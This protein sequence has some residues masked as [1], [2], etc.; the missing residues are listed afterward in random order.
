MT[1]TKSTP[2]QVRLATAKDIDGMVDVFFRSF[3]VPFFRTLFPPTPAT[4]EWL[5][6]TF[7][8][9]MQ[10]DRDPRF[11]VV[12]DVENGRMAAFAKWVPPGTRHTHWLSFKDFP[13]FDVPLCDLFFDGMHQNREELM[14]DRPHWFLELLA[15]AED[16]QGKGAGS[17]LLR[18]GLD[19]ADEAG[20]EAYVDASLEGLPIYQRYGWI[21]RNSLTM[22]APHDY[23]LNFCVRPR[24][25]GP[26]AEQIS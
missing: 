4:R 24:R 25:A 15:T 14:G 26:G 21:V 20:V 9:M 1:V 2:L 18:Y 10:H 19:R 3:T 13:G 16:Y 12:E 11:L 6:G 7:R 5:T 22:P 8:E 17:K 23:T